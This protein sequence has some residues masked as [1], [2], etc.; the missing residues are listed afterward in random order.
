MRETKLIE[1]H[2]TDGASHIGAAKNLV[3]RQG[4]TVLD[5]RYTG[6][7]CRHGDLLVEVTYE[8]PE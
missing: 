8:D 4:Y 1:V 5:A 6:A 7:R 2:G 3:K